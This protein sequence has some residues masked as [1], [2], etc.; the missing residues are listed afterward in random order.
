MREIM[1]FYSWQSDL[2]DNT[3][4]KIIR[5][6]IHLAI[7]DIEENEVKIVLDEA[8]REEPGS[9]YIPG[10]I[11]E[12]IK[13]ADIFIG[14]L[15][16]TNQACNCDVKKTPNPNVV[17]ELGFAVAHLGWKRI[18]M[19]VNTQYTDLS[20]DLPFD[21]DRHRATPFTVDIKDKATIKQSREQ[22]RKIVDTCITSII[23]KSPVKESEKK[24][25]SPD[26]IK[27]NRDLVN[28]KWLMSTIHQPSLQEH[29]E[30]G[31]RYINDRILHF[32]ESF[33]GV[34]INNLFHLYD[35][36]LYEKFKKLHEAWHTTVSFGEH[37][38]D[39]NNPNLL[40]FANPMDMPLNNK[41]EKAWNKIE[42]ALSVIN[43]VL[44]EINELIR[45]NYLEL[46][47]DEMNK[48]A[49]VEYISFKKKF[50]EE[51]EEK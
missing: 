38:H 7:P 36:E 32:W 22:L 20:K 48:E 17:F 29:V 50:I 4:R 11:V 1:I 43:Q 9:P 34:F 33:H 45:N 30:S 24:D 41:Q 47:I 6:A 16:T 5:D 21:F 27:R 23:E 51:L 15:T 40:V 14:D 8:T 39:T 37:Y 44:A 2:P 12:K 10:T 28:I 3:N 18:I 35:T 42:A 49:W 31:P 19:L 13:N 25:L 26:E 46:D